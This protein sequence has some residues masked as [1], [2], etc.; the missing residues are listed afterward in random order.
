MAASSTVA[1]VWLIL[2][3]HLFAAAFLTN[4]SSFVWI[5]IVIGA[6]ALLLGLTCSGC[7]V[8]HFYLEADQAI[9]GATCQLKRIRYS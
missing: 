1:S 6:L 9:F 8:D 4:R 2:S 7:L 5:S 3:V